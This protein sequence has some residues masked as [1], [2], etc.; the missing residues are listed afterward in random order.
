MEEGLDEP[1][2][3]EHKVAEPEKQQILI[4]DDEPQ[5]TRVLG[6]G[7]T[8]RGYE[9]Q[10]AA[11]GESA[12]DPFNDW[13]PDLLVKDLVMPNM[14]GLELCRLLRLLSQVPIIVLSVIG[15]EYKGRTAGR[16]RC[17]SWRSKGKVKWRVVR[18]SFKRTT[19]KA[20]SPFMTRHQ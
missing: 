18:C 3:E 16:R 6:I 2:C 11:D 10:V 14:D 19:A 5:I 7:L 4:C 13:Q 20:E 8:T 1:K 9:V 17:H 12:L 15:D